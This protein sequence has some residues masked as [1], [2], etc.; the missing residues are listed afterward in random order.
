MEMLALR[1]TRAEP[2]VDLTDI[3]MPG[4][5]LGAEDLLVDVAAAGLCGS[6]LHAL[7][8]TPEYAFMVDL[9][10]V[11]LGHEFSG[12]VRAVGSA[13]TAFAA[14]D[15]IVCSPSVTCGTCVGCRAGRPL[16]CENRKVVGLH[17]DGAFASRV[18]VPARACH[19]LPADLPFDLAA[20]AE[21]LSVAV[22]AVDVAD[23]APGQ[24]VVVL[25]PGPIGMAA[26][27]V[28][29]HRG[30]DVL[31]VGLDDG[32][33]LARAG[34]M[35]LEH[36]ADLRT[37][38]LDD[39]VFRTLGRRP[40]RVIEATGARASIAQSLP[41]LRPGGVL[42][43]SGIHS[44][45]YALDL[46]RFVREKKQLRAAHDTTATAFAEALRLLKTEGAALS[47]LITHREPLDRALEALTLARGK[48]AVKVMLLPT[49]DD[50][51][52]TNE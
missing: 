11:T 17:M 19:P 22:N 12:T 8:W 36:R 43:V 37:E 52:E 42:V 41:L 34:E 16:E 27:W 13:V 45:S 20:L 21:P 7:A 39:A 30:A 2:G 18:V 51:G 29:R 38:T 49:K 47:R 1:K 15:R 35:G 26:A 32:D 10:P 25:G 33:R 23:M 9:L 31:L 48:Q 14:G 40:D 3:P 4:A 24:A 50:Q 44:E 6:D 28:A 46:T 5:P